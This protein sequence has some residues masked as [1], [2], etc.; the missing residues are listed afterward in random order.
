MSLHVAEQS[1]AYPYNRMFWSI[2]CNEV[3]S[4]S[5]HMAHIPKDVK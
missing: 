1:K 3:F 2:L 5:I 4:I